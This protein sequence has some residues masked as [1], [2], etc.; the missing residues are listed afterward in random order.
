MEVSNITGAGKF[1]EKLLEVTSEGIGAV[2]ND[3]QE[4]KR[5][6]QQ[7]EIMAENEKK[8]IIARAEGMAEAMKIGAKAELEIRAMQRLSFEEV[9][10]QENIESII[11]GASQMSDGEVSDEKLDEDWITRFFN[12]AGEISSEQMQVIWSKILAGEIKQPG[13]YNLRTLQVL[14]NI[15]QSEANIFSK[16]L[17]LINS[18]G[19]IIKIGF[20]NHTN[21]KIFDYVG[22]TFSDFLKLQEADLMNTREDLITNYSKNTPYYIKITN[23]IIQFTSPVDFNLNIYSL[24]GEGIELF[25]LL[26]NDIKKMKIILKN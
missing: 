3:I 9:K 6:E 7:G 10:K 13:S 18:S 4:P 22:V 5:L 21:N 23:K 19:H 1:A 17:P 2:Y 15:N 16:I 8:M 11:E 26:N 24:T 14:R 25:N 20:N 12:I